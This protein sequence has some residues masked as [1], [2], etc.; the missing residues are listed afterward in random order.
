MNNQMIGKCKHCGQDYCM[1]C[2]E[3]EHWEE[4]CSESC[5]DQYETEENLINGDTDDINHEEIPY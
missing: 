2:S 1:E 5:Y 4:F 3:H